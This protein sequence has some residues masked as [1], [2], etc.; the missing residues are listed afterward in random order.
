MDR[1]HRILTKNNGFLINA[2]VSSTQFRVLNTVVCTTNIDIQQYHIL[3][4]ERIYAAEYWQQ[5]EV[6]SLLKFLFDRSTKTFFVDCD[7]GS[8]S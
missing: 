4:A 3:P 7:V 5:S 6:I 2:I 8:G 1:L